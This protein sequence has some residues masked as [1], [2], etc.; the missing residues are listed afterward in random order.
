MTAAL[1]DS[2]P[3]TALARQR[4]ISPPHRHEVD[5]PSPWTPAFESAHAPSP[6]SNGLIGKGCMINQ[7]KFADR[8]DNSGYGSVLE[9]ET[10]EGERREWEDK[11]EGGRMKDEQT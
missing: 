5:R 6:S 2:Q 11:D 1:P 10:G 9:G 7:E 4:F 8:S 3:R